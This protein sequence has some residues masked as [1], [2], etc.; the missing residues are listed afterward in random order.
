MKKK[1]IAINNL[2]FLILAAL[3]LGVVIVIL[4]QSGLITNLQTII[5]T[6]FTTGQAG[7]RGIAIE[8]LWVVYAIVVI[9]ISAVMAIAAARGTCA[10][11]VMAVV[12]IAM[13]LSFVVA[14]GHAFYNVQQS[15]PFVY[16][17]SEPIDFAV[18]KQCGTKGIEKDVFLKEVAEKS[19][20]CWAMYA[21]GE[22]DPLAGVIPPNPRTCFT[23]NFNL[24]EPIKF[25]EI[26]AWMRDPTNLYPGTYERYWDKVGGKLALEND[27]SD[28]KWEKNTIQKGRIFIKY[29]DNQQQAP[30]GFIIP[31]NLWGSEDCNIDSDF[32]APSDRVYICIDDRATIR[33]CTD[34][35]CIDLDPN[36]DCGYGDEDEYKY[37]WE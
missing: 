30:E 13:Y 16:C 3:S 33:D 23:I 1:G 20:D 12:C 29:G 18:T 36:T 6:T 7:I 27:K 28:E 31:A 10:N 32:D 2:A 11:P 9:I 17:P 24:K 8:M 14:I 25:N 22:Y 4:F 21:K 19:V 26:K 34:K 37:N 35:D 5:C 15:I